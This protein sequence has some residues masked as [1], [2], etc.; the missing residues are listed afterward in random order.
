LNGWLGVVVLSDEPASPSRPPAASPGQPLVLS[1]PPRLA[2]GPRSAFSDKSRK[3]ITRGKGCIRASGLGL[4]ASDPLE[5]QV[6]LPRATRAPPSS[7]SLSPIRT[8]NH[9]GQQLQLGEAG[10]ASFLTLPSA[11]AHHEH[12]HQ[13]P[14]PQQQLE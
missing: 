6:G 7:T 11:S 9:P 8:Q 3:C 4:S 13:D 12:E 1:R 10:E 5:S 14:D 2:A